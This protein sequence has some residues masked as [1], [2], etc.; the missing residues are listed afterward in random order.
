MPDIVDL[1]GKFNV[2]LEEVEK[3]VKSGVKHPHYN[4]SLNRAKIFNTWYEAETDE[5][6]SIDGDLFKEKSYI[7]KK[8]SVES[9]A[10]YQTKL[11]RMRLFP[12]EAKF[13]SSQKRIYDENNVNRAYPDGTTDF[14]RWSELNFDDQGSSITEF[15]RDKCLYV[16]EVLGFGAIVTD[17]MVDKDGNTITDANNKPVPYN[18]IVRPHEIINF[19]VDQGQLTM[20]VIK[21]MFR[22]ADG[23]KE[24]SWTAYTNDYI[25]RY[26][27]VNG[28]FSK[29]DVIENAFEHVPVT[30]LRGEVDPTSSFS[31]GKPRR[32]SLKG[33]YLA[34]S[35]LFYD[36]QQGSELF[37]HPV[38]VMT[39]SVVKAAAGIT[40]D[41]EY[42]PN[43]VK[44]KIGKAVIIPDGV[45]IP[46][47]LFY[48]ADMQG[49]QHLTEVIFSRLM[50]LIFNLA[51][52]R[53]KSI[54]KSNVSGSAKFLDNVEEQGLLAQTAMDMEDIENEVMQRMAFVRDEDYDDF[55]VTYS[56]H[57]DLSSA[58][59]IYKDIIEA[60]QYNATFEPLQRAQV[61]EYMRKRSFPQDIITEVMDYIEDYG[62]PK[63]PT[64]LK[65]I[66]NKEDLAK[67]STGGRFGA[68]K[69][70]EENGFSIESDNEESLD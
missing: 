2:S 34:A 31:L 11:N 62:L 36:L 48:Q 56:K 24:Y 27:E 68:E 6:A 5:Y 4:V 58:Q 55:G 39:E 8:S 40:P 32:Y 16:K 42:D 3:V 50:S 65:D 60:F 30:F 47:K 37:G 18:F 69:N 7:I 22:G 38:P 54:V 25:V 12:L 29:A 49:L 61:Q 44:E 33:L 46:N 53:D 20:F 17:I 64:K 45:D 14:W 23:D 70:S 13:L 28:T 9:D 67:L 66:V 35:E 43:T 51:Q 57:Y 52:V 15:Y 10:D 19:K 63:D 59:E 1:R 41:D 21:Q 26:K